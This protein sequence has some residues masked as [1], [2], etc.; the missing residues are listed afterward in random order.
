[1]ARGVRRTL[2]VLVAAAMLLLLGASPALA[3]PV[4]GTAPVATSFEVTIP[5]H[6]TV[7]LSAPGLF[8]YCFSPIGRPLSLI[9][10]GWIGGSG[11]RSVDL[12]SGRVL[13][14]SS[15]HWNG[16]TYLLFGASDGIQSSA[17]ATM[18]VIV[19]PVNDGPE[20]TPG[21]DN[22]RFTTSEDT[23]YESGAPGLLN[24]FTDP[25]GDPLTAEIVQQPAYGHIVVHADGSYTYTPDPEYSGSSDH[26]TFRVTDGQAYSGEWWGYPTVTAVADPPIGRPDSYT[27]PYG[28]PLIVHASGVLGND[29]DP[30]SRNLT[31]Q[32]VSGP[33][34]GTITTAPPAPGEVEDLLA[35]FLAGSSIQ[36]IGTMGT[37]GSFMYTPAPGFSGTD[38]FTYRVSD[39]TNLS[40]P[41]TVSIYV[42][43]ADAGMKVGRPVTPYSVRRGAR[44]LVWGSLGIRHAAGTPAVTLRCYR[45]E[46]GRWV[47]RRVLPIAS[48]EARAGRYAGRISLPQR[49][50]WRLVAEHID[51]DGGAYRSLPRYLWVR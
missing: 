2:H 16:T 21:L 6:G 1:M 41:V 27:T 49:G 44:F 14:Q 28:V 42:G 12:G 3:M 24:G 43:A 17:M 34:H 33:S 20:R 9:Y 45:F 11:Y 4:G 15:T 22:P 8:A 26:F 19:T 10:G 5:E 18:T 31:S 29:S 32:L 39:G 51:G 25:E 38:T 13:F 35:S 46:G 40:D 48:V 47:L 50:R 36:A 37:D 7:D 30:D 23:V